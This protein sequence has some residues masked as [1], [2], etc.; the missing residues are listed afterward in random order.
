MQ[1]REKKDK[2]LDLRPAHLKA[3][4]AELAKLQADEGLSSE[5]VGHELNYLRLMSA[6][7]V[8]LPSDTYFAVMRQQILRQAQVRKVSIWDRIAAAII[9]ES[10][11]PV[12]AALATA[13][14]A[15][16]ITLSVLYYPS[17]NIID[18]PT[19]AEGYGPYISI[20][21]MYCAHVEVAEQGELSEQELREYREILM[22]SRAILSSPSSLSRSRTLAPTRM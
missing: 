15:V 5:D 6:R 1:E 20:S 8:Q 10:I 13:A 14:I 2:L 21:D 9:P 4:P 12:P 22:M 16:A 18:S 11:R 19:I 3:S 7:K 17:G